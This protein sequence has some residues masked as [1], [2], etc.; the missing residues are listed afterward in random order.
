MRLKGQY[1]VAKI[2]KVWVAMAPTE[3][4]K[5]PTMMN[6]PWK[7]F[8]MCFS[9]KIVPV[10]SLKTIPCPIPKR[11]KSNP[12]DP[13]SYRGLSLQRF[14]KYMESNDYF[15]ESQN[16]FRINRSRAL[17]CFSEHLGVFSISK[18]PLTVFI[19]Y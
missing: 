19:E 7:M 3:L 14:M 8:N 17:P 18:N 2:R 5:N 4:L 11:S 6:V 1:Q 15:S 10:M 12:W 13:L 9:H 16:S